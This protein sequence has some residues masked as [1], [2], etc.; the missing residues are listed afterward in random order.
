MAIPQPTPLR[1]P[2]FG[3][4]QKIFSD[5]KRQQITAEN[6]QT[7][8][9]LTASRWKHELSALGEKRFTNATYI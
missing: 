8:V 2:H 1:A 9:T 5:S 3:F 4:S 6:L 7:D